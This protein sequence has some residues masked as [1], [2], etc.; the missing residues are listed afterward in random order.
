MPSV[1]K[2]NNFF[3]HAL[4]YKS[5]FPNQVIA[6]TSDDSVD[7]KR[8]RGR[9]TLSVHQKSFLLSHS[10]H[11][12]KELPNTRQIH[13]ERVTIISKKDFGKANQLKLTDGLATKE[14][15]IPLAV[16]TADCLAIFIFDPKSKVIALVHAGWRGT[17][18]KI[19]QKAVEL[20]KKKW[21][22]DPKNLRIAF[23]PSIRSCCYKVGDKLQ[24]YFPKET[25]YTADGFY[26][27]L[28][29]VNK[30][31]LL[32]VG[33]NEKNIFDCQICT[34]CDKRFFSYRRQGDESGRMVSVMMLKK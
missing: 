13:G 4:N 18:K 11:D 34:S 2:S 30:H 3:N 25:E 10:G 16:R 32:A 9:F 19:A 12:I 1:R 7:F 8:K 20:L 22:A 5:F 24:G 15:F 17:K 6:F 27:D 29:L 14:P 26:L 33:V 31:Q 23:S 28:P 21:K